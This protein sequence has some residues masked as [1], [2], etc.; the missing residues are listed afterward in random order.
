VLV[1]FSYAL[2]GRSRVRASS[3]NPRT[4]PHAARRSRGAA[5]KLKLDLSFG[6]PV[7]AWETAPEALADPSVKP[8]F[9]RDDT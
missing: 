9:V 5:L 8:V 6:D 4:S 1:Q 7:L 2:P 3:R